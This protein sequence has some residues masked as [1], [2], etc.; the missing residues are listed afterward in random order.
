MKIHSCSLNL[1]F[2]YCA[3]LDAWRPYR[4]SKQI[5]DE[6]LLVML[7]TMGT[8]MIFACYVSSQENINSH[9][10]NKLFEISSQ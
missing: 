7:F 4:T 2:P 8:R 9:I 3:F 1:P 5:S 6:H 10:H